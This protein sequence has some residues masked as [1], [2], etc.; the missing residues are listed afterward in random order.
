MRGWLKINKVKLN[1][2]RMEVLLVGPNSALER[3]NTL[4]LDVVEHPV[5]DNVQS[6]GMPLVPSLLLDRQVAAVSKSAFH[7][8]FW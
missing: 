4:M 7:Q 8:F 1:P 6:L 2:D 5:K 3:D